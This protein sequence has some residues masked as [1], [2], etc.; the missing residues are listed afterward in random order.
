L[1]EHPIEGAHFEYTLEDPD[2]LTPLGV[3]YISPKNLPSSVD[4]EEHI[5]KG[6]E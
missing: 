5:P 2:L 6:I 4:F 3:L 1:P